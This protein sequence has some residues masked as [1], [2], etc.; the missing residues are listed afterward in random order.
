M[1]YFGEKVITT[2]GALQELTNPMLQYA[3]SGEPDISLIGNH[4]PHL[5]PYKPIKV[6]FKNPLV[7]QLKQTFATVF[8]ARLFY[9]FIETVFPMFSP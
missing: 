8:L 2:D 6:D 3:F 4:G 7:F 9:E 1:T 5:C